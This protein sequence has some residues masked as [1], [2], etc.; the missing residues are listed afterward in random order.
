MS[1][2]PCLDHDNPSD[3]DDD[4]PF[5]RTIHYGQGYEHIEQ[6]PSQLA[7]QQQFALV[8]FL[9]EKAFTMW[10]QENPS[11]DLQQKYLM[12]WLMEFHQLS[13]HKPVAVL[14]L[15]VM[16]DIIAF[17]EECLARELGTI[18]HNQIQHFIAE[19][20]RLQDLQAR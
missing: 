20:C 10:R 2:P 3:H 7:V 9:F 16:L 1:R 19:H 12:G 6:T 14:M 18:S 4:F 17:A 13:A 15:P 5:H 8:R 11:P